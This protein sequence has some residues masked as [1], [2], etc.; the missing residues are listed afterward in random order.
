MFYWSD[1]CHAPYFQFCLEFQKIISVYLFGC[2]GSQFRRVGSLLHHVTIQELQKRCTASLVAVR[3][4]S[5]SAV[6]WFTTEPGTQ[7]SPSEYG[8]F[9]PRPGIKPT[10][11][12]MQGEISTTGP[13][14]K[15]LI[16][17]IFNFNQFVCSRAIWKRLSFRIDKTLGWY[18]RSQ[19][20]AYS[21]DSLHLWT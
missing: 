4:R 21:V 20:L 5:C 17:F 15:F 1:L 10:S 7:P 9:V 8:V 16:S 11:P 3:R 18:W 2:V 13:R 6:H 12:A 14:R 19:W